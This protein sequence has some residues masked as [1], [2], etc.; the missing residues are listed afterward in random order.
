MTAALL[1]QIALKASIVLAAA[2]VL[3]RAMTRFSA[4]AR[5]L[6]WLLALL[7]ALAMPAVQLFGPVWSLAILPSSP[8][9]VVPGDAAPPTAPA[10]ATRAIANAGGAATADEPVSATPPTP[11]VA[12]AST[13]LLSPPPNA[14]AA[15][16]DWGTTL[17]WIWGTGTLLVLLRLVAGLVWAVWLTRQARPIEDPDWRDLLDISC[18]SLGLPG[19]VQLRTS[20]RTSVPMATGLWRP[21]VL[22]PPDSDRWSEERRR[23]VLQHELAHVKRGDCLGQALAQIALAFHWFNPIAHLA[24]SQLRAEQERACDDLVLEAGTD[25]RTYADH[26]LEIGRSYKSAPFPAW[27]TLSMARPSQLEGRLIAILNDRYRRRPPIGRARVLTASV[28]AAAALAL[29][30]L[31]LTA[32][33]PDADRI[34]DTADVVSPREAVAVSSATTVDQN[35][36]AVPSASGSFDQP[37]DS[38]P[39]TVFNFVAD[40]V[41]RRQATRAIDSVL[42]AT[43]WPEVDRGTSVEEVG[44]RADLAQA[45]GGA[46]SD[47]TRRRV[48]DALLVALDDENADV[49]EEALS[50]LA[51]MRDERAIPGLVAALGDPNA[52]VRERALATLAQFDAPAAADAVLG[53][54][55]DANPDV[56]ERAARHVRALMA[57][58]QLEDSTSLDVFSALLKDEVAG[59]REQ[60]VRALGQLRTTDA[61]PVLIPMLM[62]SEAD[63]REQAAVALGNIADPRAIEPLTAALGDVEPTVRERA[64]RALGRIARGQQSWDFREV[65][66]RAREVAERA[67]V[68]AQRDVERQM[69]DMERQMRDFDVLVDRPDVF[70]DIPDIAPVPPL[71]PPPAPEP[72]T[73]P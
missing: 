53:A 35:V 47:D 22:L 59:V 15:V 28:T 56:R 11:A 39:E 3:T 8:A 51:A 73:R 68:Q 36:S 63:I 31:Q 6:V 14:L 19:R 18:A 62:D 4:G 50:A 55:Q 12:A 70:I 21:V 67:A 16:P 66:E 43:L 25:A 54:L 27:A 61:V 7:A 40:P 58:G 29:G 17:L 46:V 30:A 10:S 5:H 33:A 41:I 65:A 24:V 26:L 45:Q 49:R 20:P 38:V 64:A 1:L 69:R 23:V 37:L 48:A 44:R 52:D 72:P 9:V 57:R 32:A 42:D 13:P 2:W 60:A 34:A 71:T